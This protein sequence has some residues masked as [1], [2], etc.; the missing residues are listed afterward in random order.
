VLSLDVGDML[1]HRIA[2]AASVSTVIPLDPFSWSL[3]TTTDSGTDA[4]NFSFSSVSIGDE[5]GT[6][7]TR[8]ILVAASSRDAS[9]TDTITGGS[10]G[11]VSATLLAAQSAY[12][13]PTAFLLA[14]VPTGTT[15]TIVVNHGSTATW[16]SIAVY[17]FINLTSTT[18]VDTDIA[19]ATG[20]TL[21]VTV[22]TNDDGAVFGCF[23]GTAAGGITWG[24]LSDAAGF[25]YDGA[26][27]GAGDRVGSAAADVSS[28]TLNVTADNGTEAQS[29]SVVSFY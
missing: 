12:G 11:G 7:Q 25:G 3:I 24:S 18:P 19:S 16:C 26:P 5:P 10:I 1:F 2:K 9:G 21:S 27:A 20:T 28:G 15:G 4:Q 29:M 6:N 22:N 14:E 13:T 17:R 23:S 8:Y